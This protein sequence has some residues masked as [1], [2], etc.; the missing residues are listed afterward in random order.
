MAVMTVNGVNINYDVLGDRGPWIVLTPGG[1]RGYDAIEGVAKL[2][3]AA[4]YRV[5]VHDRRNCGA[6]D[7]LI[8]GDLSEQEIWADDLHE[9]LSHLG[10]VPVYAG[11]SSAG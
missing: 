6:S 2:I 1:R 8:E 5:V 10:A 11:G 4:G 7:V 3:S 9:L